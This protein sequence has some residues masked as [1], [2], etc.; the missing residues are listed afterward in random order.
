[1][2]KRIFDIVFSL[3]LMVLLGVP[4]SIFWIFACVDTRSKGIFIQDRVGQYGKV[5]KI[6]KLRSIRDPEKNRI[7]FYGK[8]I[9]KTKIDELPQLLNVLKGDMSV[10][11]PRPDIPGYYDLLEGEARKILELKP[12][13]TCEASL[14]YANEEY[15]LAQQEDPL[16]YND[17]VLFPDKIKMNLAY[18]YE[19]NLFKDIMIIVKTIKK[20]I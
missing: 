1:M 6:F 8:F 2:I 10:V 16:H 4:L 9:R 12:G 11:G 14:K 15:I 5:F 18:Y 13:L 17:T 3:V 20:V 19:H 7:S